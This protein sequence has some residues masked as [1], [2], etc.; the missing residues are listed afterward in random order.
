M[1]Q[2]SE[3]TDSSARLIDTEGNHN[4]FGALLQMFFHIFFT[5]ENEVWNFKSQIL[6]C[7]IV[8]VGSHQIQRVKNRDISLQHYNIFFDNNSVELYPS[9]ISFIFTHWKVKGWNPRKILVKIFK[10]DAEQIQAWR[11][12]QKLQIPIALDA[13]NILFKIEASICFVRA[14]VLSLNVS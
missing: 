5:A 14:R 1:P 10:C 2:W 11:V 8:V 12:D 6:C 9:Q 13:K 7:A 4:K 3:V